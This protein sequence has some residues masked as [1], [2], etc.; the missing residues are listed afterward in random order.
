MWLTS[1]LTLI[2]PSFRFPFLR[3]SLFLSARRGFSRSF[4]WSA[5]PITA[6]RKRINNGLL[7]EK[8]HRLID[9]ASA[10]LRK[11]KT[12]WDGWGGECMKGKNSRPAEAPE[13]RAGRDKRKEG[14]RVFS[15]ENV[16]SRLEA[17]GGKRRKCACVCVRVVYMLFCAYVCVW[18]RVRTC[19]NCVDARRAERVSSRNY[20]SW[21]RRTS[22]ARERCR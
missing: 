9:G 14:G 8:E 20:E 10:I 13:F 15:L 2:W 6:V 21:N 18:K 1:R 5:M 3:V 11:H 17:V 12:G 16:P 7:R 22:R 4:H 19:V